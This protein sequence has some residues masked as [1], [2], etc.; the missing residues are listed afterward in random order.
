MVLEQE[1]IMLICKKG[2]L[3]GEGTEAEKVG[4]RLLRGL[5][6]RK[7]LLTLH[8]FLWVLFSALV[9]TCQSHDQASRV[10]EE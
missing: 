10:W 3:S 8:E 5:N 2:G 9:L 4:R 6:V 7:F 1:V